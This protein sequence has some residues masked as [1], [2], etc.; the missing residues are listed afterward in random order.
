MCLIRPQVEIRKIV[1]IVIYRLAHEK[2]A[3][4]MVNQF[5]VRT[6]TIRKYVHILCDVLCDK[7]KLFSKYI[8]I[9][10]SDHLQKIIDHFHELTSLPNIC[11][12]I[13][14]THISLASL[15]DKRVTFVASDFFNW[16]KNHSIVMQAIC[17][18]NKKKSRMSM[19]ANLVE[20]MTLGNSKCLM[21]I[22]IS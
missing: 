5:D 6:S 9:P 2:S 18:V 11:G 22:D 10:S 7:N 4:H 3:T 17:N 12:A 1:A 19:L 14:S 13:D 20:S 21:F 8:N 16:K 15:L